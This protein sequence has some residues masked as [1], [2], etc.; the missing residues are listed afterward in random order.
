MGR[1]PK[2]DTLK[3]QKPWSKNINTNDK[4]HGQNILLPDFI[5]NELREWGAMFGCH[6]VGQ[7]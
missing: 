6:T 1:S 2:A 5:K 3:V 7:A 4:P